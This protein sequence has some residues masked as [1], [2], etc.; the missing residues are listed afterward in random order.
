MLGLPA[1]ALAGL[2][3]LAELRHAGL[4]AH[5]WTVLVINPGSGFTPGG[6]HLRRGDASRDVDIAG[7]S[8]VNVYWQLSFG[9]PAR[10]WIEF[11]ATSQKIAI[12]AL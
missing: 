10:I 5:G 11:D 1:I 3:E 6:R 8:I 4:D 9:S 2:K 12:M 7:S